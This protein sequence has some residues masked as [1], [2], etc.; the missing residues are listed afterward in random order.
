MDTTYNGSGQKNCGPTLSPYHSMCAMNDVLGRIRKLRQEKG[1]S[2][3]QVAELSGTTKSQIDKL[4]K[5]ERRLT[6]EWLERL[7]KAYDTDVASL[8]QPQPAKMLMEP[9]TGYGAPPTAYSQEVS[10]Q[11]PV[12][13]VIHPLRPG[14]RFMDTTNGFLPR[15]SFLLGAPGAFCVHMPDDS[16]APKYAAGDVLFVNPGLP[17]RHNHHVLVVFKD[18]EAVVRQFL[19]IA[20]QGV[21]LR[22]YDH[23]EGLTH[24]ATDSVR[25]IFRIVASLEQG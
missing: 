14:L 19:G 6:L 4:E 13:G 15:P 23:H 21:A 9:G 1:Y 22:R 3:Q 12:L 17:V 5:G 11:L 10:D 7:A 16:M 24:Q 18:A 25:D 2:L 20:P 8:I